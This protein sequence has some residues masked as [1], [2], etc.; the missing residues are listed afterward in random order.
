[1]LAVTEKILVKITFHMNN[2]IGGC[3]IEMLEVVLGK[4][5]DLAYVP[6][7]FCTIF[8]PV[9]GSNNKMF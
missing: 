8:I 7:D 6:A 4:V 3:S 2:L 5:R 1:M 9:N